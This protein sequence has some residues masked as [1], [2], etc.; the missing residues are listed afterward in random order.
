[1]PLNFFQTTTIIAVS[2]FLLSIISIY[3]L[4]FKLL[5]NEV[6]S[7]FAAV[8]FTFFLTTIWNLQLGFIPSVLGFYL[9]INCLFYAG[10]E[11]W[12]SILNGGALATVYP[13]YFIV[14]CLYFLIKGFVDKMFWDSA[15]RIFLFLVVGGFEFFLSLFGIFIY[16]SDSAVL[17]KGGIFAPN[18]VPIFWLVIL[19]IFA[20]KNFR[21]KDVFKDYNLLFFSILIMQVFLSVAVF[22]NWFFGIT[23][24]VTLKQFYMV[25]K[26]FYLQMIPLSILFSANINFKFRQIAVVSLLL[27]AFFAGYLFYVDSNSYFNPAIFEVGNKISYLI[28]ANSTISLD[29]GLLDDV[30]INS[31]P[32]YYDSL[33]RLSNDYSGIIR[34]NLEK[35]LRTPWMIFAGDSFYFGNTT[36]FRYDGRGDYYIGYNASVPGVIIYNN[37]DLFVIERE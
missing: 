28:P 27:L 33:I 2:L 17:M 29:S 8:L 20:F 3:Q 9:L 35:S 5:K 32:F 10:D 21:F 14:L 13:H 11:D 19:F 26:L 4:S 25:V 18:I 30:V 7:F 1:M 23:G 37:T 16:H 24:V 22:L 12:L 31:P 15:K 34:I 6:K 36:V